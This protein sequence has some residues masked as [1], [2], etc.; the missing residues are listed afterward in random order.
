[1]PDI[2]VLYRGKLIAIELKSLRSKCSLPQRAVRDALLPAGAQW[3]V[4]RTARAAMWVLARSRVLPH[5]D[6]DNGTCECW[7]LPKLPAW[8]LP[9]CDPQERRPRAPEW[10]PAGLKAEVIGPSAAAEAMMPYSLSGE[11]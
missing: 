11:Q 2:S 7:Q 6:H 10:N 4:C 8:E 9:K 1:V 5:A 3:W